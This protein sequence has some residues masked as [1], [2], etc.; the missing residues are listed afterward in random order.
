MLFLFLVLGHVGSTSFDLLWIGVC[1]RLSA[2][3][4]TDLAGAGTLVFGSIQSIEGHSGL[5]HC[6]RYLVGIELSV[7]VSWTVLLK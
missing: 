7:S 6:Q 1:I 2:A 3:L 4:G 5:W